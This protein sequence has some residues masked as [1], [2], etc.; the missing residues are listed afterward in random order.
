MLPCDCKHWRL[1]LQTN[2]SRL[3]LRVGYTQTLA[4]YKN[5]KR[6]KQLTRR[7]K[8]RARVIQMH[9]SV[10]NARFYL[11]RS[12]SRQ[13]FKP[14]VTMWSG[15][16]TIY[17]GMHTQNVSCCCCCC[18]VERRGLAGL[19]EKP[20]RR[21]D[22]IVGVVHGYFLWHACLVSAT[23]THYAKELSQGRRQTIDRS[24]RCSCWNL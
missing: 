17:A 15:A 9:T 22:G 24:P 13:I 23:P 2:K 7:D 6:L 1:A 11:S 21:R 8:T 16:R 12:V 18:F 3:R 14:R 4:S 5:C 10:A 19:G 20:T